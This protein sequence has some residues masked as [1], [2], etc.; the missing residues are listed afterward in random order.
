MI[1]D[2]QLGK[3]EEID[4][5]GV[6]NLPI[7]HYAI[8]NSKYRLS[9]LYPKISIYGLGSCIALILCDYVN[10]VCGMSH[11]L[12]PKTTKKIIQYPHKYANLSAKLLMRDLICLGAERKHIKAIIIGGSKIFDLD[13][14]LMGFDNVSSI[15][16]ELNKINIEIIKDDTGGSKGRIVIFDSKDFSLY[17]KSTGESNFNV[18]I[19]Q[20]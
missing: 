17:V 20:K 14:N 11:I 1:E 10:Y 8:V 15:K 12:L 19:N 3:I 2:S 6:I 7:G 5:N 9:K 4:R 13:D 18:F 16:E